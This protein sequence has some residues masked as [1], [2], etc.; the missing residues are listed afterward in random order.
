[1]LSKLLRVLIHNMPQ[2]LHTLGRR[3]TLRTQDLG[4]LTTA[5]SS[6]VF[7]QTRPV[8]HVTL[9]RFVSTTHAKSGDLSLFKICRCFA[10]LNGSISEA[11][12][13]KGD[14]SL[15]NMSMQHI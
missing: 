4:R 11:S 9:R 14:L 10:A 6:L 3:P 2:M 13:V 1:M 7:V 8:L 15:S 5:I 12:N